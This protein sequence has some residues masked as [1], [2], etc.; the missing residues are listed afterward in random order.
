VIRRVKPDGSIR[1][2]SHGLFC[3]LNGILLTFRNNPGKS[4]DEILSYMKSLGRLIG[5]MF[6]QTIESG[7]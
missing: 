6:V 2:F 4:S 3:A 5:E 7:K 1:V